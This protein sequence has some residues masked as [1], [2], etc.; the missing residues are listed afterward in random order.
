VPPLD[1]RVRVGG[2]LGA[3]RDFLD[4]FQA[5]ASPE[6]RGEDNFRSLAMVFGAIDSAKSGRHVSISA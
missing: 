2:H 3:I 6:T 4:A 1:P 5:G